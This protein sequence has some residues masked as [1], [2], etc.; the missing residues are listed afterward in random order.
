VRVPKNRRRIAILVGCLA[1]VAGVFSCSTAE[2]QAVRTATQVLDSSRLVSDT[3]MYQDGDSCYWRPASADSSQKLAAN[4]KS[5]FAE[6]EESSVRA[7]DT[8]DTVEVNRPPVRTIRDTDPIYASIAVDAERDEVIL[9]DTNLFGI[10]IFNRLDNTRPN[11]EST[12][13]KRVIEGNKARLEYNNGLYVD[14]KNGDIYSVASDTADEYVVFPHDASGNVAPIRTWKTPHRGFGTAVDEERDELFATIGYPPRVMV[15]KKSTASGKETPLRVIE[16]EH[17]GLQDAHGIAV[18]AKR[19]LIFVNNYGNASD[20]NT[21]GSGSFHPPSITVYPLEANG[22][23]KP[24]RVIQGENTQLDWPGAMS[25]D[26]DKGDL[27]VANDVG[28]SILVFHETDFGN[29]KP[30]RM[31]KGD[32]TY[33]S[34]PQG[35]FVD[36]KNQEVWASNLGNASATVYPLTAN[37]DVEPLRIIRSAPVGKVSLKFG[38]PGAIAYDTMREELLVPN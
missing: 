34:N 31:I 3:E 27:Y 30:V 2:Q 10:K 33:L 36:L 14:P 4:E 26:P 22:D 28:N 6:L 29:V 7:A 35:L 15:Y 13:P 25:L 5:L 11:V 20:Y 38:K 8:P 19:K 12:T 32:K 24:L 21:P 37:G 23:V 18:D 1:A 17:T 16:G 9:Q